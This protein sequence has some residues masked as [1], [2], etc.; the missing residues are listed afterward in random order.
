MHV[1]HALQQKYINIFLCFMYIWQRK[2]IQYTWL[3]SLIQA[4]FSCKVGAAKWIVCWDWFPPLMSTRI[5]KSRFWSGG[6]V[7]EFS[8]LWL[9]VEQTED[10]SSSLLFP[11]SLGS[12]IRRASAN[13]TFPISGTKCNFPP[14]VLVA[15][16]RWLE[17]KKHCLR[18]SFSLLK[19]GSLP[20]G[21]FDFSLGNWSRVPYKRK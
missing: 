2:L 3:I 10:S 16:I 11:W 5:L 17:N 1:V 7:A 12:S 19:L 9:E 6:Q 21:V 15:I 8:L 14:E 13:G 4:A 18:A 20:L